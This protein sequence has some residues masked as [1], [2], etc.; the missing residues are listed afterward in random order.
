M[1]YRNLGSTGLKVSL[2]GLGCNNFGRRCDVEQTSSIVKTALD[3]GINFFDTADIYGPSGLSE[4][5]L[6][7][8]IEGLDRSQIVIATK[9]ANPIGEG[10]LNKGASRR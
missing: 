6:G 8:A 5:F 2:V 10:A 3:L 4:A 1:Q 7:K 9:F